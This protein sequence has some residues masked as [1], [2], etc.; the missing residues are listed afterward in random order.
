MTV[1]DVLLNLYKIVLLL[2]SPLSFSS[3]RNSIGMLLMDSALV[4][5]AR[6][7]VFRIPA[8]MVVRAR[9]R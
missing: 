8:G 7:H 2:F 6:W 5:A 9:R 4:N 3:F 1:I